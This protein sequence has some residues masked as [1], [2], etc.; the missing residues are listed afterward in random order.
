M[1]FV[2][3]GRLG[4]RMKALISNSNVSARNQSSQIPFKRMKIGLSAAISQLLSP[5]SFFP[6]P[7]VRRSESSE[8]VLSALEFECNV[9]EAPAY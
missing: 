9:L 3:D 7:F 4:S 5:V 2:D 8:S 1:S 6:F